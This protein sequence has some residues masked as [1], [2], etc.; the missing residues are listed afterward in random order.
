MKWNS[1]CQ[2]LFNAEQFS[3]L[4]DVILISIFS[5]LDNE[6]SIKKDKAAHD[7]QPHIQVCLTKEGDTV[8]CGRCSSGENSPFPASYHLKT[9]HM[10]PQKTVKFILLK[11]QL[12]F[13]FQVTNLH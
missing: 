6:L 5:L 11:T 10:L 8:T 3:Y 9:H 12:H 7:Q 2:P 1:L 13:L 4:P